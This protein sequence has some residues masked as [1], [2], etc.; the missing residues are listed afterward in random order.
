MYFNPTVPH[1]SNDIKLALTNFSCRDTAD[2]SYEWQNDPYIKGMSEDDGC[3]AYRQTILDR[4]E[5]DDD[6]GKIWLDDSV[7]ALLTAL[8]DAG[9]LDNTIF[10]FQEDHGMDTKSAL[11]ENGIRIPQFIHYPDKID[12]LT[13]FDGPVS[14]VDIAATMLDYAG[15]TPSYE[16]DGQ[17]WKDVIGNDEKESYWKNERCLFFEV[18]QDRAVRCGCYKYIDIFDSSSTTYQRGNQK[19][20]ANNLDGNLFDLCDGTDEYITEDNNNRE[21]V[22]LELQDVVSIVEFFFLQSHDR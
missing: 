5:D 20:L 6:L 14:T 16:L 8:E 12:P 19:E 9:I 13:T 18:E 15:I 21:I 4:A 2:D 22:A 17:S 10:L 7:G 3:L 11:Y 1:G